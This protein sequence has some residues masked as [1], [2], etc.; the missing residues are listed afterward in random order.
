MSRLLLFLLGTLC[1]AGVMTFARQSEVDPIKLSPQLYTIRLDN[2]RVRV[3]EYH[4][5]PGEK[6]PMHSHPAGVVYVLKGATLSDTLPGGQSM[7][8]EAKSGSVLWREATSH[9]LENV[10]TTEAAAIGID[11][12]PCSK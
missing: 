6:E 4:L 7:S 12:K 1:G 8:L 11:L 2:D 9:A 5:K 10:G 3:Y